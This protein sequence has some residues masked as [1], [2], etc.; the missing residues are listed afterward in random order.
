MNKE[1]SLRTEESK[2]ILIDKL[3]QKYGVE[4]I[5]NIIN[6]I[7]SLNLKEN[8]QNIKKNVKS[9]NLEFIRGLID[10]VRT[11]EVLMYLL[12]LLDEELMLILQ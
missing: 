1:T 3:K 10:G 2:Q 12:P 8:L 7:N 4:D 5:N 9:L 11:R 6:N